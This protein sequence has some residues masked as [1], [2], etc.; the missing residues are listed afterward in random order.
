MNNVTYIFNN[1][2]LFVTCDML[3]CGLLSDAHKTSLSDGDAMHIAAAMDIIYKV[4][5]SS[6]VMTPITD[7][8]IQRYRSHP[9]YVF[10][11]IVMK[12]TRCQK[13]PNSRHEQ[14]TRAKVACTLTSTVIL[15]RIKHAAKP[16]SKGMCHQQERETPATVYVGM[17]LQHAGGGKE[18]IKSFASIGRSVSYER[19]TQPSTYISVRVS[20]QCVAANQENDVP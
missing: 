4:I 2:D 7:D 9:M 16:T 18:V 3:L 8:V 12:G 14:G 20:E 13:L 17:K 10:F 5:Q 19:L 6:H 1:I 15:K 11:G